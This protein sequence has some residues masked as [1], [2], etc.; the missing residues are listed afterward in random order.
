MILKKK[1]T[2]EKKVK[3][4]QALEDELTVPYLLKENMLVSNWFFQDN[5]KCAIYAL[6]I[7]FR[8][9]SII[10]CDSSVLSTC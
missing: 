7:N 10:R 5:F 3:L 4:S 2:A 1:P 6:H 9:N 8:T